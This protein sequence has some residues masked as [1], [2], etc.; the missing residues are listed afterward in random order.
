MYY[1]NFVIK[2]A[3]IDSGGIIEGY[4]ARYL[5]PDVYNERFEKGAFKE[6]LNR[7]KSVPLLWCHSDRDTIGVVKEF[8]EDDKGLLIRGEL[9]PT[10]KAE[11]VKALV[12]MGAVK[13]MSIGF[14][15][16]KIKRDGE[17]YVYKQVDLFEVSLT[18]MPA[19]SS[20]Q[21]ISIK[22]AIPFRDYGIVEDLDR[23]WDAG[24]VIKAASVS[25]LKKI[26]AWYDAENPD[27]KGSYKLPHHIIA[28]DG[29][30]PAVWRGVAAA[31]QRLLSKNIDIP[32][33]D[34]PSVYRHLA[35]HYEQFD[36]EPPEFVSK[37]I[38][39][40]EYADYASLVSS[41][42]E[43]DLE[44]EQLMLILK[45]LRGAKEKLRRK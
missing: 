30:Y 45:A 40:V 5:E 26:C 9:A 41:E 28:G 11:E 39:Y 2:K 31:M 29:S 18:P 33:D 6:S 19:N 1:R 3:N 22:S 13:G 24:E 34:K 15:P 8:W 4:C 21:I 23:E 32:D 27:I 20:A 17:E 37:S 35:R 7:R 38:E 14:I 44:S 36:K 43:A 25:D 12:K 16:E 10:Q 42:N